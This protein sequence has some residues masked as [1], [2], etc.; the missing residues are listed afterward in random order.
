M[1]ADIEARKA[2]VVIVK[3]ICHGKGETICRW[4]CTQ[5]G[6]RFIAVNDGADSAQGDND[7]A[8]LRNIF[9]ET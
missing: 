3:E 1:P 8:P 4:E 6:V 7:F 9:N 2:G 5:K